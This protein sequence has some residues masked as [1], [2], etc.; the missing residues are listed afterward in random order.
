MKECKIKKAQ[1]WVRVGLGPK[2]ILGNREI[3]SEKRDGYDVTIPNAMGYTTTWVEHLSQA[4]S[5]VGKYDNE[6]L[7]I[8]KR[9][10]E[11]GEYMRD[12]KWAYQDS[13]DNN[14]K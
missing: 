11:I 3:L 4:F 14:L 9:A 8:E 2:D 10:Q 12:N 5:M 1:G 7:A 6:A 13:F